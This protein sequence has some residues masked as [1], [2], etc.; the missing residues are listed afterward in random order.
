MARKG[1]NEIYRLTVKAEDAGVFR[2]QEGF[3]ISAPTAT[4]KSRIG[5]EVVKRFCENKQTLEVAMYIVPLKELAEEVYRQLAE[6]LPDRRI[7]IKTGDYDIE[8]DLAEIDLVVATYESAEMIL[9]KAKSLVWPRVI[10]ADEISYL[11]DET[12][13][14]RIEGL[15]SYLST[16]RKVRLYGLSAVLRHPDKI[17]KWLGNTNPVKLLEGTEQDRPTELEIRLETY[18]KGKQDEIVQ[19]LV[20]KWLPQGSVIVFCDTKPGTRK[21]SALLS[22]IVAGQMTGDEKARAKRLADQVRLDFRYLLDVPELIEKGVAFHNS[23][24]EPAIRGLISKGFTERTIKLICSTSTLAAG[25]NLPA[26]TVIVR[27]TRRWNGKLLQVSELL[28]MLGRAGRPRLDEK[29]TAFFLMESD[30][31]QRPGEVELVKKVQNRE[32]EELESALP[33]SSTNLMMFILAT[34]A[35]AG[36]A[37]RHEI[38]DAFRSSYW[39]VNSTIRLPAT[40]PGRSEIAII[41]SR[42]AQV[43][44]K[45]DLTSCSFKEGTLSAVGGSESYQIY[46]SEVSMFCGCKA[47]KLGEGGCKHVS[48][49]AYEILSGDTGERLKDAKPVVLSHLDKLVETEPAYRIANAL[50]LLLEYGFVSETQEDESEQTILTITSDGT[51]ALV[52]YLL[53]MEHIRKLRDRIGSV[54]KN[55]SDHKVVIQWAMQ[56]LSAPRDSVESED[57]STE[58][59][60]KKFLG[61]SYPFQKYLN[62]TNY[63]EAYVHYASL[64]RPFLIAKDRLIQIFNAYLA[65]CPI[66]NRELREMI[67]LAKRQVTYG[68]PPSLLPLMVLNF[69]EIAQAEKARKLYDSGIQSVW[70]LAK[71]SSGVVAPLLGI[72]SDGGSRLLERASRAIELLQDFPQDRPGLFRLSQRIGI[73][74]DDIEAYCKAPIKGSDS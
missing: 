39:I 67:L 38:M 33:H 71:S 14:I 2:L 5:M 7:G 12:R 9:R 44:A 26:R 29:G 6:L 17:V 74:V 50:W 56:D 53:S 63:R 68:S 60:L 51:Q 24:L 35:R 47:F 4:G 62:G 40:I 20:K 21:L 43:D 48:H 73:A 55:P 34:L 65:F 32:V 8:P 42:L 45:I 11:S 3:V 30:Y 66:E 22:D 41:V 54:K 18:S 46:F 25:I 58:R 28:N 69:E 49:L 15:L 61:D 70:E 13:G 64:I 36:Q 23:D 57:E 37:T 27:D 10:I 59:A 1:E 31:D 16:Q 19:G 52:N 72:D